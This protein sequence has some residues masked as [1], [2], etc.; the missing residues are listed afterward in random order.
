MSNTSPDGAATEQ[1]TLRP[2]AQPL[3][4]EGLNMG[5]PASLQSLRTRLLDVAGG[6][7]DEMPLRPS[8]QHVILCV[9]QDF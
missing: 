1:E 3:T 8:L 5:L 7:I 4:V 9:Q 6:R 2:P